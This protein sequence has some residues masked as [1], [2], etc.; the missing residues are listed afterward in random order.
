MWSAGAASASPAPFQ[1]LLGGRG[2]VCTQ[3]KCA[4][5]PFGP[6]GPPMACCLSCPPSG[7]S[8]WDFRGRAAY[9]G[10]GRH[11]HRLGRTAPLRAL[12]R[13]VGRAA[14]APACVVAM[15]RTP[16]RTPA[17]PPP[18]LPAAAGSPGSYPGGLLPLGRRRRPAL[19]P[20]ALCFVGLVL[21]TP[22]LVLCHRR[23][24]TVAAAPVAVAV[25]ASG[26]AAPP[27]P[28]AH[29][30]GWGF[31]ACGRRVG[32]AIMAARGGGGLCPSLW[33]VAVSG[34]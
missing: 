7:W 13:V 22:W 20:G 9:R 30:P 19:S 23:R 4:G 2:A 31:A 3:R 8:R 6:Q 14:P 28:C 10:L 5:P 12:R 26:R 25:L 11:S 33:G 32:C 29:P 15:G 27:A 17:W 16:L 34:A 1:R 18:H 24:G 21:P